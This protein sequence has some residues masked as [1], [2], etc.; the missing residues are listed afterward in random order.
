VVANLDG[1]RIPLERA[2]RVS[3]DALGLP[4]FVDGDLSAMETAKDQMN[5][6]RL[7]GNP[8]EIPGP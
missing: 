6:F 3:G 2:P 7:I 8:A 5:D 4:S 1:L